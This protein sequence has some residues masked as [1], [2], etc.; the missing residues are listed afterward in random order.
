MLLSAALIVFSSFR[1][2]T[3]SRSFCEACDVRH[4]IVSHEM[5][6][7]ECDAEKDI[8]THGRTIYIYRPSC[9]TIGNNT[10]QPSRLLDTCV[11]VYLRV[12]VY[13]PPF[14]PPS[15]RLDRIEQFGNRVR[16]ALHS[17]GKDPTAHLYDPVNAF[18]LVNRYI[19]GW[20]NI[21][22]DIYEDNGQGVCI[23]VAVHIHV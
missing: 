23:H 12:C 14:P 19:N 21:H 20:G 8:P 5:S 1:S 10:F 11:H 22:D 6:K 3:L 15:V 4:C 9:T 16:S 18:Q 2:T 7:C 17:A 13:H